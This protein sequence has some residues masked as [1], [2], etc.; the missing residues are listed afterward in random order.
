M[1]LETAVLTMH[2]FYGLCS[3]MARLVYY[4]YGV[5]LG[6]T[7]GHALCTGLA[8]V[9]GRMLAAKISEKTVATVGGFTFLAFAAHSFLFPD[10]FN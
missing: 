5:T 3:R 9:G 4:R 6:G 2:L 8:V 10:A 7:L 1:K